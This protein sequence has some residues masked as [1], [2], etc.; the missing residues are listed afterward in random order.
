M[1]GDR[2]LTDESGQLTDVAMPAEG[3]DA[4]VTLLVAEHLATRLRQARA[5]VRVDTD[6]IALFLRDAAGRYG[7]FWRKSARAP[8]AERELADVAIERLHRLGLLTHSDGIVEPLPAIA[9]FGQTEVRDASGTA[10]LFPN[11]PAP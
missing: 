6:E 7:K 8:G 10:S 1:R 3:T 11:F 9:R 5:P 2:A 4:H